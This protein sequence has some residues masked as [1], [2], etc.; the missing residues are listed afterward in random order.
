MFYSFNCTFFSFFVFFVKWIG[1]ISVASFICHI[2][3]GFLADSSF[4]FFC[5]LVL[6]LKWNICHCHLGRS[7]LHCDS[8]HHDSGCSHTRIRRSHGS[9]CKG[10]CHHSQSL[11][12]SHH[13][14]CSTFS[15]SVYIHTLLVKLFDRDSQRQ[16]RMSISCTARQSFPVLLRIPVSNPGSNLHAHCIHLLYYRLLKKSLQDI[17]QGPLLF[18]CHL[19][20]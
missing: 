16:S 1:L 3:T 10:H 18:L 6:Y 15:C 4:F 7:R 8:Q 19:P 12:G 2:H 5:Y 14:R 13:D 17:R 20:Q 11:L 9:F